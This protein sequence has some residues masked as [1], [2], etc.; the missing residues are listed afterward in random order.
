MKIKID[1][2]PLNNLSL[3]DKVEVSITEYIKNN[4]LKVGDAIP[5]ELDFAEALGVSRTVIRE[6]LSRLRTI[7][8]IESIKH[9]GML[10]SQPD[11][12]FNLEKVIDSNLLGDETLKDIFELRLILEMGMVDLLFARKTEQDLIDLDAI[13]AEMEKEE[14][15]ST[16]FSLKNEIAFHGKLYEMSRNKT[17]QRF[18]DLL[19]P[20]FQYVHIHKLEDAETYMYKKKYISHRDLLNFLK[21]EDIKGFRKGMKQHLEPHFNR[22]FNSLRT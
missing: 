16:I 7:G 2:A 20:V 19:L 18:Q 6:A 14:T 22:V 11:I 1:I 9:K 5:K 15:K 4:N 17:V 21:E 3:V 13:V 10:L 12:I 8:I